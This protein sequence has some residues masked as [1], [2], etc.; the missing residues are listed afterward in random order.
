MKIDNRKDLFEYYESLLNN[1]YE[2]LRAGED[3]VLCRL[4]LRT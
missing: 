4:C 2:K 3:F 1:T